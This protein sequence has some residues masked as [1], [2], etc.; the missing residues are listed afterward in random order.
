MNCSGWE[1]SIRGKKHGNPKCIESEKRKH[2]GAGFYPN[3]AQ[4]P[5]GGNDGKEFR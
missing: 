4:I 5:Y 2:K 1:L 3:L